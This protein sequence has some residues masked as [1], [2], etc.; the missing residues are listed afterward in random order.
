[1][2]ETAEI[3]E[4][5][6]PF[7]KRVALTIAALAVILSI[8]STAGDNAKSESLLAATRASNNWAYYQSKSIKEHSFELQKELISLFPVAS[9]DKTAREKVIAKYEAFVTR[10]AKEKEEIKAKAEEL[11]KEVI[12]NGNIND[13]CDLAAV[14]LQ[15][16]IV[17]GSVAILVRWKLFWYVSVGLGL[18]GTIMGA[19]PFIRH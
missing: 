15:I 16:A 3:P 7:E 4:A 17:L 6:D 9:I 5:K 19:L 18:V 13:R 14:F 12:Y 11:E 8:I 2:T 10:Y 1:M